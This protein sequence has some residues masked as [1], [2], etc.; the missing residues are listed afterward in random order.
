MF[1]E[2]LTQKKNIHRKVTVLAPCTSSQY[3]L[4]LYTISDNILEIFHLREQIS[5]RCYFQC[6]RGITLKNLK[7]SYDSCIL[8][9]LW[10][11]IHTW[12]MHFMKKALHAFNFQ[13][14]QEFVIWCHLMMLYNRLVSWK[15]SK[16]FSCFKE[17][18]NL[19]PTIIK[20]T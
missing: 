5:M 17:D 16:H 9:T 4:N 10:D 20:E 7:K 15:H 3:S 12:I 11:E 19:L 6:S 1:Q 18:R 8:Y 13:S 14:R 2:K